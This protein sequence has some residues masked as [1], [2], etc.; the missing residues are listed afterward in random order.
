MKTF[1]EQFLNSIKEKT[2]AQIYESW[3]KPLQ[4]KSLSAA[5]ISI[6]VPSQ[7]FSDWLKEN[8]LEI[9]KEVLFSLTGTTARNL[10]YH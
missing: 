5:A 10:F 3:F 9:I 1:W 8:Y 6:E 7:F 2:S 4:L